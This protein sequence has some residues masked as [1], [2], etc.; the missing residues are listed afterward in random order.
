M[1]KLYRGLII[2]LFSNIENEDR[3]ITAYCTEEEIEDAKRN[4][5]DMFDVICKQLNADF[6]EKYGKGY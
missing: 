4:G 3:Y 1:D 5:I 2:T 6:E